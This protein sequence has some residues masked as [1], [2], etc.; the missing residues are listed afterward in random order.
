MSSNTNSPSPPR[1][2]PRD[3]QL[4][5]VKLGNRRPWRED[6]YVRLLDMP[7][8]WLFICVALIYGVINLC[9]AGIYLAIGD[10][11]ENARLG[12]FADAFFFSVQTMA[13]IGYGKLVP[14]GILANLLVTVEAFLGFGFFALV[15]GL[16]F[17]KFSRP[18]ARVMFSDKAVVCPYN[19]VPHLMLRLAN[20]RGNRIVDAG[21]HLNVLRDEKTL[22]GHSMRRFHDLA[23]VRS[24]VPMLQL[25]W[26]VMHPIDEKS[27]LYGMTPQSLRDSNAEVIVS[28]TGLDETLMQ[29]IHARYSYMHEDIVCNAAFVDI[30]ERKDG[31]VEVDYRRFNEVRALA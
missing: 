5:V 26:T 30:L 12:S 14:R 24:R 10:G 18:T 1:L 16:M 11:I 2:L 22:E 19:G 17:A 20:Q 7:W 21:I 8:A 29:T 4:R 6:I 13:T 27:P 25:T 23:L 31:H 28:L 15:T 9:F 3:G